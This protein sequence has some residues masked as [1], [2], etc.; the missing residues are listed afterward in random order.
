M[1]VCVCVCVCV[2]LKAFGVCVQYLFIR[3][4]PLHACD[5]CLCLPSV[6]VSVATFTMQAI[7]DLISDC[8]NISVIDDLKSL[9]N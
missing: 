7:S 3:V 2:C 5:L 6:S 8:F 1:C 4:G 9:V